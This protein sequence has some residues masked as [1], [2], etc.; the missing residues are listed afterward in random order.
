MLITDNQRQWLV[1]FV[2]DKGRTDR[3]KIIF[4]LFYLQ[5]K[6]ML[7]SFAQHVGEHYGFRVTPETE[8]QLM[9]EMR[10]ATDERQPDEGLQLRT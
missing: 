2:N 7:A 1:D 3:E 10:R 9:E 4:L 8:E 5:S 6:G